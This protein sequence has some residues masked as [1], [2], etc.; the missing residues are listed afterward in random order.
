MKE[1]DKGIVLFKNSPTDFIVE[2]VG[3]KGVSKISDS[4]KRFDDSKVDLGELDINDRRNFLSCDLEK[5]DMDHFTA[6]SL[7]GKSIRKLPHEIGYAGSKDKKAWTCQRIS[8]FAP[9]I[10]KIKSF[11]QKGMILKNF[12]WIRHKIKIGDLNGN[13]FTIVLRDADKE[14][15]KIL[16]RVRNTDKIP[17]Y[18]G[19][20][21]FG[22]L[23]KDN[24]LIGKLIFKRKFQEAVFAFLTGYGENESEEVKN[25]KKRLKKE[26]NLE[27]AKSYFPIDLFIEMKILEHLSQ[28]PG[29][30]INALMLL[31]EKTLLMMGQSVQSIL[32]NDVLE[33]VNEEG[34]EIST[35][36]IL[37]FDSKIPAGR[38]G[39]IQEE[40]M[41]NHGLDIEDFMMEEMPFL[42]L[43]G[44][45]RK[46]YFNVHDLSIQIKN[47]EVFV[48][49]KKIEMSFVLDSGN[50]ATTFL[51]Q[52]F[53]LR[54]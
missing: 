21:R 30:W 40:V 8:I 24:A 45:Q 26:R 37:G 50:Y 14:A 44:S 3:E 18:F 27:E 47:D 42:S 46:A 32:F 2:E 51:E 9:D 39:K 49:G 19:K 25:A 11:S 23:R 35:I 6:F 7:L 4:T 5:I 48:G 10:E 16:S 31:G 33:R 17:N 52:F 28:F 20:Q 29:D 1:I 13:K 22:S 53:T 34:I 41:E 38:F 43:K 36:D 54:E 12:R 15:L